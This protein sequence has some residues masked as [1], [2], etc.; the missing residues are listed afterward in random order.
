M[1]LNSFKL[2][3]PS[4]ICFKYGQLP[5]T[6]SL[7]LLSLYCKGVGDIHADKEQHFLLIYFITILLFFIL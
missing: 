4:Q 7:H 3:E 2:S 1:N 6:N 5:K